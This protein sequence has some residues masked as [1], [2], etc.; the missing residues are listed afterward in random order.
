MSLYGNCINQAIHNLNSLKLKSRPHVW[1]LN[2][3]YA[4]AAW[5]WPVPSK[6]RLAVVFLLLAV[7]I[8][9]AKKIVSRADIPK[10][11]PIH[12][13][14]G[15]C[16]NKDITPVE[17]DETWQDS[18]KDDNGNSQTNK[19]KYQYLI[20]KHAGNSYSEGSSLMSCCGCFRYSLFAQF[21]VVW[22]SSLLINVFVPLD[23]TA[24]CP[25]SIPF[26]GSSTGPKNCPQPVA[27]PAMGRLCQMEL[28]QE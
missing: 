18:C 7:A 6:M 9:Q 20:I 25:K 1:I 11:P 4:L 15:K 19:S 24:L 13:T 17:L 12:Q 26:P 3:I 5:Y 27:R 2:T 21:P 14:P 22:I 10:P 8:V 23:M 28:L 16:M